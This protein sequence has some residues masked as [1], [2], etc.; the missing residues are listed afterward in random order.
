LAIEWQEP[1][2]TG[3]EQSKKKPVRLGPSVADFGFFERLELRPKARDLGAA[4]LS[5]NFFK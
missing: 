2:A 3:Q 4:A 5:S 1:T